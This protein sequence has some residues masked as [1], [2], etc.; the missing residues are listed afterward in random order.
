MMACWN[1]PNSEKKMGGKADVESI[2]T[3]LPEKYLP[4]ANLLSSVI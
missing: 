4:P 3:H 1:I 2:H